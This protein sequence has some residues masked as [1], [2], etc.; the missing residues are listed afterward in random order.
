MSVNKNVGK[1]QRHNSPAT[2]GRMGVKGLKS[3]AEALNGDG[4]LLTGDGEALN[5]NGNAVKA[6]E[7]SYRA[8][9]KR[10]VVTDRLLRASRR[11]Y[12]RQRSIKVRRE[13]F[14]W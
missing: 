14:K 1:K 3:A 4:E 5:G 9:M 10:Y 12:G 7:E 8:T 6:D 11:R 2:G 13:V